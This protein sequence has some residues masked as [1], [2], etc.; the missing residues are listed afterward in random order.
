MKKSLPWY[1]IGNIT[2]F[3]TPC[4]AVYPDR[5]RENINK[6]MDLAGND[7]ERLRPHVKTYKMAE[8]VE[9][10]K[11]RGILKFKCATIAEAEMLAQTG[12]EDVLLAYQPVGKK[13]QRLYDLSQKYPETQF[14][15]L[16][17]NQTAAL[18][19]SRFFEAGNSRIPVFID[20]DVGM[21][22]TGVSPHKSAELLKFSQDL[23]G[24]VPV[25]FHIYDG[26]LS[27][28]DPSLRKVKC[29]QS[30]Q[31]TVPVQSYFKELTGNR[32]KIVAGGS[33]TFPIH[34]NREEV[35][36]S[37]GTCLLWDWGYQRIL[38]DLPFRPAALVV[39]R[40]ISRINR[41]LICLDLGHKSIA[42]ENP[43]PRVKFLNL[44]DQQAVS[45]SEEH[46]VLD[47]ED[48]TGIPLGT[49]LFGI[50]IH[51]CPT[52]ALYDEA[53]VVESNEIIGAWRIMARVRKITV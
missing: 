44:G 25:G 1:Q 38:P 3:D 46:L 23:K 27:D 39:S 32:P 36:S 30:F 45:H 48:N 21:H 49:E 4:L 19:L 28:S 2:S 35:E 5:I 43:H 51:I 47:V 7:P 53:L 10:Q 17:D 31:T 8:I 40:V 29:D 12:A 41:H 24:L 22:R 52:C 20:L 18:A 16:I 6:M 42:S 15:T 26:H 9:L 34:A 50:P 13:V 11:S 37:P 33:P 14:S